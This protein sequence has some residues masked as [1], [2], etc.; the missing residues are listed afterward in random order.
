MSLSEL[1][2]LQRDEPC[3]HTSEVPVT[4]LILRVPKLLQD[5]TKLALLHAVLL[6]C[7]GGNLPRGTYTIVK[8]VSAPISSQK[9]CTHRR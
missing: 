7:N 1:E 5:P 9:T 6:P 2:Y 8:R 4:D 3:E